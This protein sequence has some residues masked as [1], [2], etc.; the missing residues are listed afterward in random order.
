MIVAEGDQEEQDL[1]EQVDHKIRSVFQMMLGFD[2]DSNGPSTAD[3]EHTVTLAN[4]Q[5]Y[6]FR[7]MRRTLI[8]CGDAIAYIDRARNVQAPRALTQSAFDA[9][10]PL[11][12]DVIRS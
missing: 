12:V 3:I 11:L 2:L 5:Q 8:H 10:K 9:I 1:Y 6:I 7:G 4:G